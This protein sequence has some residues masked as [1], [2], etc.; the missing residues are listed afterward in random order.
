MKVHSKRKF[1]SISTHPHTDGKFFLL[2]LHNIFF[3]SHYIV[4]FQLFSYI[5]NQVT[6]YCVFRRILQ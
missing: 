2:E 5:L 1:Q 6:I 4:F 3:W